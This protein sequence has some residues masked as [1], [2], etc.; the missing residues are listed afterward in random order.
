MAAASNFMIY[1]N[2][3]LAMGQGINTA[4]LGSATFRMRLATSGYTPNLETDISA[5]AG[6]VFLSAADGHTSA[7][8][9][10]VLASNTWASVSAGELMFD[11]ANVVITA[12]AAT[13][14]MYAVVYHEGTGKLVGYC[15]L[16]VSGG[17]SDVA[18]TQLT[19]AIHASGMFRLNGGNT[20]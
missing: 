4:D 10:F 13:S 20:A 17:T 8:A 16:E 1:Q 2:W 9:A 11:F 19:V 6:F 12:S 3:K 14:A 5:S 7:A 18:F 15:A